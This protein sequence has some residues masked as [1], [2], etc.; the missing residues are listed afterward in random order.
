MV[1]G[2]DRAA[3]KELLSALLDS[4]E[5]DRAMLASL[6]RQH[7]FGEL[8]DL[9]HRVKGGARMVKAQALI[10]SCETLEAV[11]E[12]QERSALAAAVMA[13]DVAIGDLHQHMGEYYKQA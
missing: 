3:L 8:H 10:A 1:T 11:C 6:Q 5:V 12:R 2:D 4:L 13:I 7:R 9:A